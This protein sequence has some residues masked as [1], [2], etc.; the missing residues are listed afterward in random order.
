MFIGV[1]GCT[2]GWVAVAIAEGF[3]RASVH[4][5]FADVI[6]HYGEADVIGVDMPL[7]L[8]PSDRRDAD[9]EAR[10]FL[11]GQ[12]SCVFPAPPRPVLEALDYGDAC[13]IALRVSGKSISRQSYAIVEKMRQVDAFA[14]EPRLFEVHPEVSFRLLGDARIP[15]SKKTY[16][17][18]RRRLSLLRSAGVE[19]PD[20]LDEANAVG[21]DDVID[22][23]AAAWSARRIARGEARSFPEVP[24]QRDR[25]GRAIAIWG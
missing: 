22:A 24:T 18:M 8:V 15:W 9:R 5:D 20:D 6:D 7:G 17:G 4:R 13:G 12:A 14:A 10:R 16:G 25:S 21:I 3:V 19:L 11:S 2:N 23:A 1:D